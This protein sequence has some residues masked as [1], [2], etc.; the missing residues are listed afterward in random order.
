MR[1]AVII[2]GGPSLLDFD[3]S[4]ITKKFVVYGT[5]YTY[6][7]CHA[8]VLHFADMAMFDRNWRELVLL[9]DTVLTTC[10]HVDHTDM[11]SAGRYWRKVGVVYYPNHT[12]NAGLDLDLDTTGVC[13]S[14]S[15]HQLLN[16]AVRDGVKEIYLLGFDMQSVNNVSEWH[17]S[18]HPEKECTVEALEDMATLWR[19]K[20]ETVV[21][22]LDELGVKVYNSCMDSALKCFEFKEFPG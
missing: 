12:R 14:N 6:K 20:F 22:I 2:G 18:L 13:G 1:P 4:R 21:P 3:F 9:E 17:T 15:G 10:A 16:I 7:K 5:N 11:I 19:R 8:D